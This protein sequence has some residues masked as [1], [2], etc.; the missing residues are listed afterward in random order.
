MTWNVSLLSPVWERLWHLRAE[1]VDRASVSIVPSL[2]RTRLCGGWYLTP[3]LRSSII[4]VVKDENCQIPPTVRTH[5]HA[6][7]P[8]SQ[9]PKKQYTTATRHFPSQHFPPLRTTT[10]SNTP[11]KQTHADT[12]QPQVRRHKRLRNRTQ[13]KNQKLQ[14]TQTRTKAADE[15]SKTNRQLFSGKHACRRHRASTLTCANGN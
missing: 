1:E 2:N 12:L 14:N 8:Q 5:S 4:S 15:A 11:F 6:H 10:G 3:L 9:K 13:K 7:A